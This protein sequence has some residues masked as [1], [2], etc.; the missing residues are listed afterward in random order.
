MQEVQN[1]E[2]VDNSEETSD[3]M[4]KIHS[5]FKR[6]ETDDGEYVVYDEVNDGYEWVF[7]DDNVEAVE[8]LHGTN[9]SVII[10]GGNIHAVFNRSRR[11]NRWSRDKQDQYILKGIM[12]SINRGYLDLKDGQWFG[13]LIGPKFH[14]NP[15]EVGQHYWIPFKRY[16]QKH[17]SYKSW[18][19]PQY[20]KT[21]DAISNWF[22][23]GLFSLFYAQWHGTD[24]DEASVLNGTFCEGVMFTHP[25]GRMAKLRRDMFEWYDGDRH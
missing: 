22:E 10:E 12:N 13:E 5:P 16:C 17:L 19:D 21:F 24:L 15:H 2:V 8:K 25:D 1:I 18:Q 20:D 11:L 14:N 6:H 7:E 4:P 9:V 3:D 23:E